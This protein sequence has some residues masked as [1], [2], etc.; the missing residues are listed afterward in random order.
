MASRKRS[1]PKAVLAPEKRL[2]VAKPSTMTQRMSNP[3]VRA[4]LVEMGIE[5]GK[6]TAIMST[7][8]RKQRL[9]KLAEADPEHPDPVRA[10][11]ELN[12]MERVYGDPAPTGDVY[13]TQI[14]AGY[15]VEELRAMIA[16]MKAREDQG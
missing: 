5:P 2:A 6:Y 9:S 8:K 11:A 15:T 10:I 12:R 16:A 14:F 7:L 3:E 4:A 13:N 1:A